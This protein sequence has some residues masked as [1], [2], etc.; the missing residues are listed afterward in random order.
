MFSGFFGGII[1]ALLVEAVLRSPKAMAWLRSKRDEA[2]A[3][4]ED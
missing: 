4:L 2:R 1:G 3:K